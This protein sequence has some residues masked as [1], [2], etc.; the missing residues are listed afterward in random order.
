ME[1]RFSQ[2]FSLVALNAQ[3]SLHLTNAKKVALRC[4]AAAAILELYL[5]QGFT[6]DKD[7]VTFNRKDLER[8][9]ITLYQE[10]VLKAVLGR[11]E[12]LSDTLPHLLTV[13]SKL[14]KKYLLKIERAFAD[15]LIG[16]HA[17][18][19]IPN[20][21]GCDLLFNT[22]GVSMK[23]YRSNEELFTRVIENLRAET[24]EEGLMTDESI[25][26]L[27]L[28]RES[29]C[30]NDIFSDEEL[31]RVRVRMSELFENSNL[32]RKVLPVAIH[33]SLEIAIKK[34]LRLKRAT[35]STPTG[36]GITFAFPV[37]ERSQS[38][39]IDTEAYFESKEERLCDVLTRLREKG[40][41]Y[42]VLREG[43]VP[44]IKIDN[45]IYEAVPYAFNGGKMPIHGVHLRRYPLY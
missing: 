29:G 1:L 11:K 28:M 41:N 32:A 44:L 27:W 21:L 45:L 7:M 31:K 39:F 20:L 19:E 2:N 13:V 16:N 23:E 34:F 43:A 4:I 24:I 42:T 35:M 10:T 26:M 8:P 17:I 18:E 9:E 30:F 37:F 40:H 14:S 12:S 36:T 5:E 25:F 6:L 33:S 3:D 15:S 38:V 22:A